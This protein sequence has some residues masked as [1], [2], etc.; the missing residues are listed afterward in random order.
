MTAQPGPADRAEPV[1]RE[2]EAEDPGQHGLEREDERR[3]RRA[4]PL[5]RPRLHEERD[6]A[7]EDARDEQ[8]RPH[9]RAVRDLDLPGRDGD[10]RE[11]D[12]RRGHLRRRERERVVARREALHE[13]DLERVERGAG[14]DEQV[15]GGRAGRDAAQHR[16]PEDRERDAE[17]HRPRRADAE[18][19]RSRRPA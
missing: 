13:R 12:E 14:E 17:P 11:A 5:L 18:E 16:Q 3:L 1:A 4:R 7:R 19:R 9:R 15:A 8:R 2:R 10:D 6:R